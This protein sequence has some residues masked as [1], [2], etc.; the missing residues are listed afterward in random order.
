V[1]LMK[2]WQGLENARPARPAA[3]SAIDR[4][5]K[6]ANILLATFAIVLVDNGYI[7]TQMSL[8]ATIEKG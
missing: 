3:A 5:A 1:K 7:K 4:L 6:S 8:E 2:F